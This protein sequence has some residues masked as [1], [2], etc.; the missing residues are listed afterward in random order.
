MLLWH[1]HQWGQ[2]ASCAG[3]RLQRNAARLSRQQGGD[4]RALAWQGPGGSRAT[5]VE[6]GPLRASHVAHVITQMPSCAPTPPQAGCCPIFGH[7]DST[8]IPAVRPPLPVHGHLC[9]HGSQPCWSSRPWEC[10]LPHEWAGTLGPAQG[11]SVLGAKGGNGAEVKI[12]GR[13]HQKV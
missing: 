4:H 6:R 10:H 8:L 13:C 9:L 5:R 2:G 1:G 3:R 12:P 11:D 7:S